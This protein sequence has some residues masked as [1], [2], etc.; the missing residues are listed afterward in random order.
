MTYM[1]LAKVKWI[2]AAVVGAGKTD[3][4]KAPK[5]RKGWR[6]TQID[7][8]GGS[9]SEQIKRS[10]L[11]WPERLSKKTPLLIM[12]GTADW[13]VNPLDSIRLSQELLKH[14]VPFRLIMFEG[15]D[16]GLT[17]F[18]K[19]KNQLTF[20]WFDRFLKQREKLPVLKPH[21]N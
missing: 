14:Q 11:Y 3:E 5:F 16:H 20:E 18:K 12:H 13:R 4:V 15:G 8:Y 6:E 19:E 21:G 7:L 9:R 10:A 17:E 1:C 2:K